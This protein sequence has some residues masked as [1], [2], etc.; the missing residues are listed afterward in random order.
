[1]TNLREAGEYAGIIT[2]IRLVTKCFV[3]VSGVVPGEASFS[4]SGIA[5]TLDNA[6]DKPPNTTTMS[7]DD[8]ELSQDVIFDVLSSS[9][10][11][12]VLVYLSQREEPVQLPALAEEVAAWEME[13]PVEELTSQERKRV[14]VSLYQTHIPKLEEVGLV[15][16]DQDSGEVSLTDQAVQVQG[17]LKESDSSSNR[18]LKLATVLATSVAALIVGVVLVPAIEVSIELVAMLAAWAL[19]TGVAA[20]LVYGRDT[21]GQFPRTL[22]R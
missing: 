10:R 4:G 5:H 17:F 1:M 22:R 20:L 13:T 18:H 7:T 11:R 8:P 19:V 14:Y 2:Y 6:R 15:D 3:V 9:R 21:E 12:Y 16:Y